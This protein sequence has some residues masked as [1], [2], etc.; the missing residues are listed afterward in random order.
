MKIT[1]ESCSAQYDL[2]DNRIPPSGLTMKCPE[3]LHTFVVKKGAAPAAAP[4]GLALTDRSKFTGDEMPELPAL[5]KPEPKLKLAE[6]VDLPAPR[7][8]KPARPPEE[9]LPAPKV[10]TKEVMDLP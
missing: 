7:G 5:V 8:A 4:A 6:V 1:C 10:K 3:C 9:N 2:D